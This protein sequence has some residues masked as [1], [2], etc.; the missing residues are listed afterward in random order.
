VFLDREKNQYFLLIETS[1]LPNDL[2]EAGYSF[3]NEV[4]KW[5]FVNGIDEQKGEFEKR[6]CFLGKG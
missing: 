2:G 6:R 4:E 1:N 3:M 5:I